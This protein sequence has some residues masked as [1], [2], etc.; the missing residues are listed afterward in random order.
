MDNKG[1]IVSKGLG[2]RVRIIQGIVG[3]ILAK[4]SMVVPIKQ[5]GSKFLNPYGGARKKV[6]LIL[7]KPPW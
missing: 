4:G 3:T 5:K 1:T 6:P 2:F 7:G